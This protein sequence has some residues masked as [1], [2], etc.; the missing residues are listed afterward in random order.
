M[1][2]LIIV[3]YTLIND[4]ILIGYVIIDYIILEE[5]I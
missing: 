3:I 2:I 1:K 5:I 4:I